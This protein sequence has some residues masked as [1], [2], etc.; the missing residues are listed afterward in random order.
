MIAK[1]LNYTFVDNEIIPRAHELD[2]KGEF[3]LDIFRALGKMGVFGIRYPKDK[4]G[5]G[6]NNTLFCIIC[7]ELSRGLISLGAITAMQCLMGTNFLFLYG[8]KEMREKYSM[9]IVTEL[10]DVKHAE[11]VA[12]YSDIIQI[13]ARNMQNFALLKTAGDLNMPVL[14]KRGLAATVEEWLNAAEYVLDRQKEKQ[15]LLCERGIRTFEPST[16]NT[17]DL[18]AIPVLKFLSWLPVIADPSHAT[19]KWNYVPAV[20]RGSIAAA[21]SRF[22]GWRLDYRARWPGR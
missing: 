5:S 12:G 15:V 4:G 14:L 8:T 7:E 16:R 2:E 22:R 9:L 11:L 1:Q 18:N 3:P 13:G 6:G 20:G 19:G 17:F 10:L 21:P